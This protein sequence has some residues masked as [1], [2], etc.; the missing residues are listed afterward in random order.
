MEIYDSAS[1]EQI[2]E[3]YN[4]R[5]GTGV[6]GA[7]DFPFVVLD[8]RSAHD[9]M[10][11]IH[12]QTGLGSADDDDEDDEDG[13]MVWYSW[14][15][16]MPEASNMIVQLEMTAE[17]VDQIYVGLKDRF[18]IEDGIFRAFDAEKFAGL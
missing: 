14:R 13:E 4:A 5:L 1:D 8:E 6:G 15:V 2:H 12:M 9:H 11:V 10:V 17:F 16:R 7:V 18:T 3:A